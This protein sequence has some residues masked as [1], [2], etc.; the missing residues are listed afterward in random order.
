MSI[1]SLKTK[2]PYLN[3]FFSLLKT[4]KANDCE[5]KVFADSLTHSRVY[6]IRRGLMAVV[7]VTMTSAVLGIS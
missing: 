4:I 1:F 6:V 3:V 7:H 2:E 5:G